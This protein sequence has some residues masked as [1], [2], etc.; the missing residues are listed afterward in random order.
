MRLAQM[1]KLYALTVDGM[2]IARIAEEI[3]VP[4]HKLQAW[5]N[6]DETALIAR[7]FARLQC[8]TFSRV[9]A[10]EVLCEAMPADSEGGEA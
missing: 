9:P 8:W 5:I 2:S 1:L 7:Q 4:A 3:D 6:G 10:R